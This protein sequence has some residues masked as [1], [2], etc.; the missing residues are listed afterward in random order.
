MALRYHGSKPGL[1]GGIVATRDGLIFGARTARGRAFLPKEVN[2]YREVRFADIDEYD[3]TASG[4]AFRIGTDVVA[5]TGLDKIS[6]PQWVI[7][8]AGVTPLIDSARRSRSE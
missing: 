4:A 2:D 7:A 5:F 6:G 8:L 3:V 1:S